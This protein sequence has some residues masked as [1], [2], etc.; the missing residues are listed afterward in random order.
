MGWNAG[1]NAMP[2]STLARRVEA[3]ASSAV[4]RDRGEMSVL[5][6]RPHPLT[7]QLTVFERKEKRVDSAHTVHA[8]KQQQPWRPAPVRDDPLWLRVA[9]IGAAFAT[10]GGLILVPVIYVFVQALQAGLSTYWQNLWGDEDTR[11]AIWLTM[12]VAPLSVLGN[13]LFGIAAAWTIARF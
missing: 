11:H 7:L 2:A 3:S 1:A 4:L 5:A 10:V 13:T 6:M 12:S 8:E 9:L